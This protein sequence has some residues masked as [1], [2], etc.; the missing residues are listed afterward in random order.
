MKKYYCA[1][2]GVQQ[3]NTGIWCQLCIDR[4][5]QND[6]MWSQLKCWKCSKPAI[7]Y[8]IFGAFCSHKHYPKKDSEGNFNYFIGK[9][10]AGMEV[11]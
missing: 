11:K 10:I 5:Q 8:N 7:G 9:N 2:C 6:K 3:I 1:K 4:Q